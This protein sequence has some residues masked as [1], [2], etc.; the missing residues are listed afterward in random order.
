MMKTSATRKAELAV[1]NLQATLRDAVEIVEVMPAAS[2]SESLKQRI[3]DT[4]SLDVAPA[5][6][7]SINSNLDAILAW[8]AGL[9]PTYFLGSTIWIGTGIP[10]FPLLQVRPRSIDWLRHL[11]NEQ[12]EL[13]QVLVSED[14]QLVGRLSTE[15][16]RHEFIAST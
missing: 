5:S 3:R 10:D 4:A 12:G 8:I 13:D 14:L 1:R 9:L 7:L 16:T 6:T 11:V 2:M 15:E